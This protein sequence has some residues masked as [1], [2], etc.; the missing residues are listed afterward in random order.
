MKGR[1]HMRDWM[2]MVGGGGGSRNV[3]GVAGE[4]GSWGSMVLWYTRSYWL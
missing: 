3:N 4:W 1:G 2:R